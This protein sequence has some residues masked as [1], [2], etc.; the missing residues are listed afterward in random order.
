[1]LDLINVKRLDSLMVMFYMEN[2]IR[3]TFYEFQYS[4]IEFTD[5]TQDDFSG[6]LNIQNG[7]AIITIDGDTQL[8]IL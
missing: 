7:Q 4:D 2:H 1:M 8:H 3:N 5:G 6:T